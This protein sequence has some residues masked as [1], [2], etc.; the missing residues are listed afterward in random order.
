MPLPLWLD[1]Q[2]VIG[3]AI[4]WPQFIRKKMWCSNLGYADRALIAAFGYCNGVNRDF[5][6]DVLRQINSYATVP[7]LRKIADLYEYWSEET[8]RGY[9]RRSRYV[10]FDIIL[11]RYTD[12]NGNDWIFRDVAEP[13]GRVVAARG[14]HC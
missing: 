10:S 2:D 7:R 11:Q 8:E 3:P 4:L 9:E 12:L 14:M 1:L 13:R 6:C 5:L